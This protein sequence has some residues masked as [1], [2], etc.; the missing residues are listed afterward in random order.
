MRE[1]ATEPSQWIARIHNRMPVILRDDQIEAWLDLSVSDLHRLSELL[2]A[3]AE[4]FLDYYP[5][6]KSLLNSGL[7][8]TPEC[9]EQVGV[10]VFT[11]TGDGC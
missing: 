1:A 5:V 9:A 4:D 2:R 10:E 7:I 3:P 11:V 6:E 8:D